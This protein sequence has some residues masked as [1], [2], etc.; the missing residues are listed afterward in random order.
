MFILSVSDLEATGFVR[1]D[2]EHC[3]S[4]MQRLAYQCFPFRATV[5]VKFECGMNRSSFAVGEFN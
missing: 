3:A 5:L 2:G 1:S 4:D